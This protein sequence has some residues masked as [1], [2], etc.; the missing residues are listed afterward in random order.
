MNSYAAIVFSIF[1][2]TAIYI[3]LAALRAFSW[4]GQLGG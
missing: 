3:M 2:F 1:N 4:T